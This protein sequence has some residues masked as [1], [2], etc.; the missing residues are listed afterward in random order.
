M[1]LK[2][3]NHGTSSAYERFYAYDEKP[4][5]FVLRDFSGGVS[6]KQASS[7]S[8]CAMRNMLSD[9]GALF[10]ADYQQLIVYPYSR[11]ATEFTL[12]KETS[13]FDYKE[14]FRAE[15][16]QNLYVEDGSSYF[17]SYDGI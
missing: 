7:H 8:I 10:T 11:E 9:G 4:K 1:T 17:S 14:A 12:P 13:S 15:N 3:G 2:R 6:T 5:T 16:L